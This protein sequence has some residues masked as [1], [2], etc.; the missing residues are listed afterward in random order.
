MRLFVAIELPEKVRAHLMEAQAAMRPGLRGVSWT[1]GENL[2]LTLK[3]L[4]ETAEADVPRVCAGLEGVRRAEGIGLRASG[5]TCFPERG[6][7]RVVAAGFSG[8]VE[9]LGALYGEVERACAGLGFAAERRAYCACDAGPA[10]DAAAG[11]DA[12]VAGEGFAAVL[13]G[14]GVCGEGGGVDGKPVET[15]GG[16]I[17]PGGAVRRHLIFTEHGA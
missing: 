2:H 14:A 9:R 13:A 17:R 15:G 10:E 7:F 3:F 12:G 4:G 8:E 1:R 5:V 16:G 11:G 6:M